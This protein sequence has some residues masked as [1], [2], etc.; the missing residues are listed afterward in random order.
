MEVGEGGPDVAPPFRQDGGL[1]G[2]FC[3]DGGEDMVENGVGKCADYVFFS[4]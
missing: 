3:V 2:E 4:D 1:D